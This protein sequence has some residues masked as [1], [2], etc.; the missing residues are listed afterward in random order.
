MGRL[1]HGKW[2]MEKRETPRTGASRAGQSKYAVIVLCVQQHTGKGVPST[3]GVGTILFLPFLPSGAK[4]EGRRRGTDKLTW[5]LGKKDDD[6][7]AHGEGK[8]HRRVAAAV[9]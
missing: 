9:T 3:T 5:R 6:Q 2:Q 4:G 1:K 7:A 8:R